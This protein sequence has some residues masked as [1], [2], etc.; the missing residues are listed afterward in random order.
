[1]T[2]EELLVLRRRRGLSQE[3]L[4]RLAGLTRTQVSRLENG[5]SKITPLRAE[6]LRRILSVEQDPVPAEEALASYST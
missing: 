5:R 3:E 6:Q 1:M 4:G 2:S